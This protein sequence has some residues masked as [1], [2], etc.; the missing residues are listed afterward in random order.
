MRPIR[1]AKAAST[2]ALVAISPD[3]AALDAPDPGLFP[4]GA[5]LRRWVRRHTLSRGIW[6][7]VGDI[8]SALLGALVLGALVV[9]RV[10]GA[11]PLASGESA[12]SAIGS[13]STLRPGWILVA[14]ALLGL[15]LLV[16]PLHRLGPLFLR[17]FEAAW[18]LPLPGGRA[19]LLAPIARAEIAIAALTGALTAGLL[20]VL[21]G[22]DAALLAGAVLLGSGAGA[23]LIAVLI[24]LQISGHSTALL[25]GGLLAAAGLAVLASALAPPLPGAVPAGVATALGVVCW[26][27]LLASWT[28][29]SRTMPLIEDARILDAVARSLGAHV[30]LLSL[31]TRALGRVLAAPPRRPT[32]RASMPVARLGARLPRWARVPLAIAQ[33]DAILLGREPHRLIQVVAGLLLALVPQF[34]PGA[35]RIA[36][37]AAYA[38]GGWIATLAVAEPARRAWFDGGLDASW[39]ARPAVVRM[40][41]L[42]VPAAGMVV[43]TAAATA[44]QWGAMTRTVRRVLP[45][46]SVI[47]ASGSAGAAAVLVLL[48]GLAWAGAALRSGY[49]RTPNFSAGLVT[50]PVG[51]L[52]PGAVEMLISGPDAALIG[53]LPMILV[54][55]GAPAALILLALQV[56][57]TGVVVAWGMEEEKGGA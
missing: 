30:S 28:R 21:A 38:I 26:A 8:Y 5:A 41:H 32:R 43:W 18:M 12:G 1:S 9:P 57:L 7:I 20:A 11:V 2:A 39:P 3:A 54:L 13:L 29:L 55:V 36:C 34:V 25:R 47:E 4:D 24:H 46:G 40:G 6:A 27:L 48:A 51:S 37:A 35:G 44:P 50:S 10:V 17:P 42:L 45:G 49:R 53:S 23:V 52:P 14:A 15:S 19:G 33:G 16:G 56:V 31:D 22:A